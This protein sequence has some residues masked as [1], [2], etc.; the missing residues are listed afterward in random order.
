MK[1][2][3]IATKLAFFIFITLMLTVGYVYTVSDTEIKTTK[4][5]FNFGGVYFT[6]VSSAFQNVK[7]LTANVVEQDWS[8]DNSTETSNG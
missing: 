5:L 1:K 8:V 3:A 4:E 6:W 7:S 2:Q